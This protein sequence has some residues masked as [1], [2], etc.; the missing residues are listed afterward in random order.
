MT[1]CNPFVNPDT[2]QKPPWLK[3]K[4]PEGDEIGKYEH[5]KQLTKSKKLHTICV[6]ARCPN[7]NECW[8]G[9]TA[10]FLLMGDICTRYCRFCH[11]KS[12]R[13][14]V[15][16][17]DLK[18]EPEHLADAVKEMKLEYIVLTSVDRDDLSDQGSEHFATCVRKVK[19][20]TPH[21]LVELLI[22]DFRADEKCLKT[23]VDSG[24]E[25]VG[26][27]M[28][29]VERLQGTVRDNRAGYQQSLSVLTTIKKINPNTYTKTAL[30]LGLGET[31]EEIE[32]TMDDLRAINC[33][34][35]TFGQ[36]LQPSKKHIAVQS[37]VTPEKFK[38][39][40]KKAEDKGF[41]YCAAGPYV[42]SSYRAGEF[43]MKGILEKKKKGALA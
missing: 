22:P 34:I 17:R 37:Y 13:E 8:S 10:T 29:T 42:R 24:A 11:T 25:V 16:M 26:H 41:L 20:T 1:N 33:D 9:G 43:F 14:G 19:E 28:E 35:I 4:L 21:V 38:F 40:Q 31:D 23:V 5:V 15:P 7:I 30:M 18:E 32:K 6:E 36:Y 2:A 12:A 39:W 27:N 3:I